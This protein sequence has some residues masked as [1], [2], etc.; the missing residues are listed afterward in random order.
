M[1]LVRV[2]WRFVSCFTGR[3][4]V[5]HSERPQ[6]TAFLCEL[7]PDHR[8]QLTKISSISTVRLTLGELPVFRRVGIMEAASS[9]WGAGP[10]AMSDATGREPGGLRRRGP[11]G[12]CGSGRRAAAR[13]AGKMY[14][15]LALARPRAVPPNSVHSGEA[16]LVDGAQP[17]Y[18]GGSRPK[19]REG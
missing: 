8:P 15:N 2:G 16:G 5:T 3:R 10:P 19:W 12:G 11:G 7:G 6:N 13:R 18:V 14:E 17:R 1:Q 9:G 4:W